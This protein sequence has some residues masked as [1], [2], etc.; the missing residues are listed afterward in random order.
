MF[1]PK[2]P[3]LRER[4]ILRIGGYSELMYWYRSLR[5][6]WL[7]RMTSPFGKPTTRYTDENGFEVR[8]G[9]FQGLRYP[10]RSLGHT[11]YLA[12]K[13]MGTYEPAVIEFLSEQAGT[14][15]VFVDLGSGDGFF[16]VGVGRLAPLRVIGFETNRFERRLA[17]RIAEA[18]GVS[19]ESRGLA[20]IA[21]LNGLPEGKLL[22][23]SDIEGLEEDLI[24]PESVPRLAE[25]TMLVETHEQ[26]RPGVIEVLTE[27]FEDTHHVT[28][29]FA[30]PPD[31]EAVPEISDWQEDAAG[32]AMYDGHA[33]GDSWMTF[34]PRESGR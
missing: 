10:A 11:N 16:C 33:K 18:N 12:A 5:P 26:F 25:A 23:L 32:L 20:G 6:R 3:T 28:R 2:P 13:L 15:E 34:V 19:F 14:A 8:R 17:G 27:R 22:L 31:R 7:W 21:Q 4:L 24:D 1:E 29:L 30:G 9:P